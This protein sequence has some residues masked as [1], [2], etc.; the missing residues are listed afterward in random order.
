MG[1]LSSR[2]RS[3]T[4]AA[5]EAF[6]RLQLQN[7]SLSAHL[8]AQILALM[9]R[10]LSQE[11]DCVALLRNVRDDAFRVPDARVF[12]GQAIHA[13]NT[14]NADLQTLLDE[15]NARRQYAPISLSKRDER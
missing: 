1:Q 6:Y 8:N 13:Q 5:S 14:L 7:A 15:V 4:L 11:R 9:Q 10:H 12:L 2:L 3:L